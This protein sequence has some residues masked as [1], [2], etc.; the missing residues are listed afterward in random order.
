MGRFS[1]HEERKWPPKL[2]PCAYTKLSVFQKIKVNENVSDKTMIEG[3][4][5][6]A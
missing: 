1:Q 6:Y 5:K 3:L 2:L 4:C